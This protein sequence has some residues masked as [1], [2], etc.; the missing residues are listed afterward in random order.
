METCQT[1]A[2]MMRMRRVL[3]ASQVRALIEACAPDPERPGPRGRD[4]RPV[5][6]LCWLTACRVGE[7]V[8]LTRECVEARPG[9]WAIFV[10]CHTLPDGRQWRPKRVASVRQV[11]ITSSSASRQLSE[12]LTDAVLVS[13]A[14]ESPCKSI[15]PWG[16]PPSV[17]AVQKAWRRSCEL[18][19]LSE[20][21]GTHALRRA[22]ISQALA[23]GAPPSTVS[24]AAGH[25]S[26]T[27]TIVYLGHSGCELELPPPDA[28][29]VPNPPASS[30]LAA[31][32]ERSW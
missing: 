16:S 25:A 9:G 12:I 17:R 31:L 30:W 2:I 8:A 29:P 1:A 14:P 20:F 4:Y 22:R 18:L 13:R 28:E 10:R 6:E 32:R 5:L 26:L 11:R 24:E 27:S 7:A 3:T 19:G 15:W 21:S 23:A